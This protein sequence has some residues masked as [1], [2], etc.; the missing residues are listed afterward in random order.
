MKRCILPCFLFVLFFSGNLRGSEYSTLLSREY[1]PETL[2]RFIHHLSGKGEYYRAHSEL[3]RLQSYYP[4]YL[5]ESQYCLSRGYFLLKGGQYSKCAGLYP[6][7]DG[8]EDIC[9]LGFGIYSFDATLHMQKTPGMNY[10]ENVPRQR[11]RLFSYSIW[12]REF[13]LALMHEKYDRAREMADHDIPGIETYRAILPYARTARKE[14]KSPL[15]AVFCGILPGGGYVYSGRTNT[16]IIAGIVVSVLSAVT[17]GAF[18]TDNQ[19]IGM[20]TGSIT[21]FFYGGSMLGGYLA[22]MKHNKSVDENLRKYMI[23][24]LKLQN[25]SEEIYKKFGVSTRVP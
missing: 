22:T 5:N 24:E 20:V 10:F 6:Q 3:L 17:Y 23:E 12:K 13:L 11:D 21:A 18:A 16:G 7:Y 25:D 1:S 15:T 9:V 2:T 4:D 19:A 8:S 14:Y